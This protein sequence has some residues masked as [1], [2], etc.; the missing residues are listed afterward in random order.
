MRFFFIIFL[1]LASC[2]STVDI[3]G[4]K[5]D[6]KGP[7]PAGS[8]KGLTYDKRSFGGLD[9]YANAQHKGKGNIEGG[10]RVNLYIVNNATKTVSFSPKLV[11]KTETNIKMYPLSY[12]DFMNLAYRLQNSPMPKMPEY[13]KKDVQISG[14]ASD[15]Y[16]NNYNF[17]AR[18][19]ERL[20][21]AEQFS[22]GYEQGAAIGEAVVQIA[23]VSAGRNLSN[24]GENHYLRPRYKIGP[25]EKVLLTA[26]FPKKKPF[27]EKVTLTV[28]NKNRSVSFS[29]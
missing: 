12:L 11:L 28:T 24:W 5:G 6:F 19:R 20:S 26:Y 29:K 14:T 17:N 8:K 2:S 13:R 3:A 16:G 10:Y 18:A 22:R 27:K 7:D 15:Q 9:V 25:G 1:F 4:S 21:G 23:S